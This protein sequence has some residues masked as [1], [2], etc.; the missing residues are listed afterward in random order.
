MSNKGQ[1][2]ELNANLKFQHYVLILANEVRGFSINRM[3]E[4]WPLSP[5]LRRLLHA[6][7]EQLRALLAKPSVLNVCWNDLDVAATVFV[8]EPHDRLFTRIQLEFP[9]KDAPCAAVVRARHEDLVQNTVMLAIARKIEEATIE[10][11][12]NGR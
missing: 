11:A 1:V 5:K 10:E 2:I 7:G 4:R 3:K 6:H 12:D 8:V 9:D